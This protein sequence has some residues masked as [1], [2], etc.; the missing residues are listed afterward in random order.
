M[1]PLEQL[2]WGPFFDGQLTDEERRALVPG[3]VLADL[4]PWLVVR[5]ADQDRNTIVPGKIRGTAAAPVVGDFVL[6]PPVPSPGVARVLARRSRISRNVAGRQVGEQ[7]LAANVDVVFVVDAL[8]A[9]SG[10]MVRRIERSVAAVVAGGATPVVLLGKSD[11]ADELEPFLEAA[12]AAAPGVEVRAVSGKHGIGVDGLRAHLAAGRTA[13]FLGPSGAGKSTLVNALLGEDVQVVG[14]VRERDGRGRHTTTTR[15]LFP[16]TGGGGVVDGPGIRELKLW[17]GGGLERTFEEV[18][19]VAARCRFSDCAHGGEPGCA[20]RAALERGELEE[21][22][23]AGYLK[24]GAE[25]AAQAARRAEPNRAERKRWEKE[26]TRALRKLQKG[27]G[28][29]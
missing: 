29:D 3:R 13:A 19:E 5:Y 14:G 16:L 11:L 18:A 22:R 28:D 17:D 27:R 1:S 12:R 21:E 25:A 10:D 9:L 7:V 2:G 8:D 23:V 20:V 6:A 26:T 24:L 4:G 15:R